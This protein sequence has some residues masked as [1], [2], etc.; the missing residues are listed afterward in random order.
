MRGKGWGKKH[1][2]VDYVFTHSYYC[3]YSYNRLVMAEM[4][5][6]GFKI[7]PL[8][9]YPSYRGKIIQFSKP[10]S[11]NCISYDYPEH[12]QAYLIDCLNNL[13][14]KGVIL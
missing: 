4:F 12:N 6:R 2:T 10:F 9:Y 7:D 1:A 14:D 3:L 13:K 11:D 5:K 8:W